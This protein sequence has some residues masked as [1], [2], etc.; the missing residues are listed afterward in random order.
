MEFILGVKGWFDILKSVNVIHHAS[1]IKDK[2]HMFISKEEENA[3]DKIQNSF[4]LI[5][6]IK[7]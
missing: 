2:S 1:R 7:K 4:I 6:K 5:K 3:F